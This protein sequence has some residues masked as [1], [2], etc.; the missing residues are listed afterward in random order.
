MRLLSFCEV[1]KLE[2]KV[3][4]NALHVKGQSPNQGR[5]PFF[6]GGAPAGLSPA[7]HPAAKPPGIRRR[8][9]ASGGEAARHPAAKPGIRRRSRKASAAKPQ[10]IRR[11]S[12]ASTSEDR[13]QF[14]RGNYFQLR[15]RTVAGFLVRAPATKLSRV[16]K[17]R[18]LHVIVRNFHHQLRPQRLPRQ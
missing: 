16:T 12:R 14:V 17:T 9:R 13:L 5:S 7:A 10:G 18:A 11:R 3:A 1:I 6:L 4:V 8:S 15:V 2:V